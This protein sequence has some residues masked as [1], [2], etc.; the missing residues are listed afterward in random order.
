MDKI[1]IIEKQE[2]LRQYL[3]EKLQ[4]YHF[5]VIL[6][7][8][9][10]EGLIK[11]K[12][13]NPDLIIMNTHLDR[14]SCYDLLKEKA[15]NKFIS[16]IPV[17]LMSNKSDRNIITKY[18]KFKI[19]K[20]LTLPIKIDN[21]I[22]SVSEVFK[23]PLKIDTTNCLIDIHLNDDILFIEIANGLN[24]DKIELL[25]YRINQMTQ[26]Y[27]TN[28]PKILLILSN[29][30]NSED[31]NNKFERLI[32]IILSETETKITGIKI[33][34]TSPII[35][36]L[37]NESE[38]YSSL[39]IKSDFTDAIDSFGKIDIFAYGSEID[40]IKTELLSKPK[41]V[42]IDE[43]IELSFEND[44]RGSEFTESLG[45]HKKSTEN[46]LTIAV[47]DDDLHI[48]EYMATVL[49]ETGWKILTYESGQLF[50][51]DLVHYTPDMVFLDIMMP[52]VNGFD[53]IN[54]LKENNIN[55]QIVIVTAL[56]Q[57]DVVLKVRKFGIINY[58]TKPL[59]SDHVIK[60]AQELLSMSV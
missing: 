12:N 44:R 2:V 13:E 47:V 21:F 37:V 53:V 14:L 51:D 6:S 36:E 9:G 46:G 54:Y 20:F 39:Q 8:N 45:D 29:I 49:Q 50:I 41:S 60:K 11:I 25:K 15:Q 56:T 55:T 18:A 19:F 40:N 4:Q 33:L 24:L 32:E 35:S 27:K 42:I 48:L 52:E 59:D 5:E 57:R 22:K 38:K 17:I 43:N 16:S 3:Q 34:S 30:Q 10:F 23:T 7:K 31:I 1:L 28:F 58:M 26:I